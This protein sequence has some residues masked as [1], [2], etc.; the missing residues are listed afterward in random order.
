M[1]DKDEANNTTTCPTCHRTVTVHDNGTE[2]GHSMSCS[3]Y[4]GE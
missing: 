2:S 1:A 4:Y 3:T